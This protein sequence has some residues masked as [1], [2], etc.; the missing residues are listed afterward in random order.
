MV[1]SQ[2]SV[3]QYV[4]STVVQALPYNNYFLA[5]NQL[6]VSRLE[7]DEETGLVTETILTLDSDYSVT[8]ALDEDGGTVTTIA[9]GAHDLQIGDVIRLSRNVPF[10]QETDYIANQ[11]FSTS[12]LERDLDKLTMQ[13]QQLSALVG[14]LQTQISGFYEEAIRYCPGDETDTEVTKIFLVRD[15]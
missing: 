7:T 4:L 5:S 8:G 6:R 14:A 3:F 9:G 2:T 15:Q 11:N 13:V 1:T 12:V 10:T